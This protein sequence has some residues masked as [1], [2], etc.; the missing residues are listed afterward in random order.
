[1]QKE[2]KIVLSQGQYVQRPEARENVAYSSEFRLQHSLQEGKWQELRLERGIEAKWQRGSSW[3]FQ[4]LGFHHEH[5]VTPLKGCDWGM[6]D[7]RFMSV[8][9]TAL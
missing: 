9:S 6:T 4:E 3:P 1:M 2:V 5:R 8:D 7:W